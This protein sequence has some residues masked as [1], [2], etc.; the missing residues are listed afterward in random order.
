MWDYTFEPIRNFQGNLQKNILFSPFLAWKMS[1][2]HSRNLKMRTE[3]HFTLYENM[4]LALRGIPMQLA[5]LCFWWPL[6]NKRPAVYTANAIYDRTLMRG[7][8]KTRPTV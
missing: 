4:W 2:N 1:S 5:C 3:L 6:I 7:R 8:R